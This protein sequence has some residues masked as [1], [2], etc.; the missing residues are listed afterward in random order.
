MRLKRGSAF[1]DGKLSGIVKLE[2]APFSHLPLSEH[3]VRETPSKVSSHAT[4]LGSQSPTSDLRVFRSALLTLL[5]L[6]NLTTSQKKLPNLERR[7]K[8]VTKSYRK[9]K[10]NSVESVALLKSQRKVEDKLHNT[11]RNLK[12]ASPLDTPG[13]WQLKVHLDLLHDRNSRLDFVQKAS[14][15]MNTRRAQVR[16]DFDRQNMLLDKRR[17]FTKDA[18]ELRSRTGLAVSLHRDHNLMKV[19]ADVKRNSK[20]RKG[21]AP[22]A[23]TSK[24]DA[25]FNPKLPPK[26][27]VMEGEK[28]MRAAKGVA[29]KKNDKLDNWDEFGRIKRIV[30]LIGAMR[31]S[32][33]NHTSHAQILR[34]DIALE[35]SQAERTKIDKYQREKDLSTLRRASQ[36]RKHKLLT[37]GGG[38]FFPSADEDNGDDE[39]TVDSVAATSSIGSVSSNSR[40]GMDFNLSPLPSLKRR[41]GIDEKNFSSKPVCLSYNGINRGLSELEQNF[42][43][44]SRVTASPRSHSPSSSSSSSSSSSHV[45]SFG[46]RQLKKKNILLLRNLQVPDPR[47]NNDFVRKQEA[48]S[49]SLLEIATN[50]AVEEK[51][52]TGV[53]DRDIMEELKRHY[54]NGLGL[55]PNCD[56]VPFSRRYRP[57]NLQDNKAYLEDYKGRM[58][59]IWDSCGV[60]F[61]RTIFPFS[62]PLCSARSSSC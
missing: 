57:G 25:V 27:I 43:R 30:G 41:Y 38:T 32:L 17:V 39:I 29:P 46:A 49:T 28:N 23:T 22:G 40:R 33:I 44:D 54:M 9:S 45:V 14:Y 60:S 7:L 8:S 16:S 37:G 3:T 12:E 1:A 19:L 51:E 35:R 15:N 56:K 48:G 21:L 59:A 31:R 20:R 58:N 10:L 2:N 42:K 34:F 50:F 18:N 26:I 5:A 4:R 55:G 36:M 13:H 61:P 11:V 47:L 6:A 53:V 62:L 24:I 52:E